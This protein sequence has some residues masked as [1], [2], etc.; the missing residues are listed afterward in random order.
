MGNA[1]GGCCRPLGSGSGRY[2]VAE[3]EEK[4][5]LQIE[6]WERAAKAKSSTVPEDGGQIENANGSVMGM[7]RSASGELMSASMRLFNVK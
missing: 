4:R 5:R 3:A 1:C 6:L 2:S 7:S